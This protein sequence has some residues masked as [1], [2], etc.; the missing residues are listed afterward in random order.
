[1]ADLA[2]TYRTG[3]AWGSGIGTNLS[4]AQVDQNFYNIA[5]ALG[6]L[7]ETQLQPNNIT[8]IT[9]SA[10]AI[11]F[12]FADGSTIG[13]L[14]LPILMFR[15][16]GAWVADTIYAALDVFTVQDGSAN[17]GL[18]V[19]LLACTPTGDFDPNSTDP[20]SGAPLY[21]ELLPMQPAN[22]FAEVVALEAF[23]GV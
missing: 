14:P 2:I 16:R 1:M 17:A 21:Q 15:Y 12:T 5:V 20:A 7:Q 22:S 10:N 6:A 3:G 11:N 13:P 8:A 23:G 4:A 18:Y 19:V 9:T